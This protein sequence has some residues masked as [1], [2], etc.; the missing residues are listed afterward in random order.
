MSEQLIIELPSVS[1]IAQAEDILK[2]CQ[3]I[4]LLNRDLII[5][6]SKVE[7][8]DTSVLQLLVSLQKT[9]SEQHKVISW[10]QPSQTFCNAC[11][12]LQLNNFFQLNN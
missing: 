5:D 1:T 10:Q 3:E 4:V 6:A 7:K 8:I 2:E 9:I 11:K 12:T